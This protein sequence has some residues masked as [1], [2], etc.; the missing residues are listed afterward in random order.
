MFSLEPTG[1]S[2]NATSTTTIT[3]VFPTPPSGSPI[4]TYSA[5]IKGGSTFCSVSASVEPKLCPLTPLQAGKSYTVT[6]TAS[7]TSSGSTIQSFPLDIPAYTF[8]D[9]IT[10]I[11]TYVTP[12]LASNS[13]Y[14]VNL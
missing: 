8:P 7:F 5:A 1:S 12:S 11:V 6:V 13:S 9:G 14:I 10:S 2:A 4:T 3:V